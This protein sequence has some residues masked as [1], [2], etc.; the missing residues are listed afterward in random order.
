MAGMAAENQGWFAY[1]VLLVAAAAMA[2]LPAVFRFLARHFF[3]SSAPVSESPKSPAPSDSFRAPRAGAVNTRY[4]SA[5]QIGMLIG[6]P[7][8]L[9]IPLAEPRAGS[10]AHAAASLILLC[11]LAGCGLLYANR[12][13]D[14]RWIDDVPP[15]ERA[16]EAS[17][18]REDAK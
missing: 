12:K 4:F 7:L 14:L 17:S 9:V 2:A 16:G 18:G 8:L 15:A 6:L 13:G 10:P 5:A 11:L 1:S 3:R